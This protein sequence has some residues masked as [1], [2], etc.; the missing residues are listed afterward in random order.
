MR[1]LLLPKHIEIQPIKVEH[2]EKAEKLTRL[3][4]AQ[5]NA[6]PQLE[7]KD[8]SKAPHEELPNET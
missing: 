6:E 5:Q 8:K 3:H 2:K 7:S 4:T 1:V